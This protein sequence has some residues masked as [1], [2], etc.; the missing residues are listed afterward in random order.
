[1]KI[2]GPSLAW[3]LVEFFTEH[4]GNIDFFWLAALDNDRPQALNTQ[5]AV[6]GLV[7]TAREN[8]L[9]SWAFSFARNSC[10][11]VVRLRTKGAGRH[12]LT[13]AVSP[14]LGFDWI[15]MEKDRRRR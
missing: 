8:H 13:P 4:L 7:T 15:L 1:M 6:L 14:A 9:I 12:C 2:L 3:K 10:S 5:A 11:S